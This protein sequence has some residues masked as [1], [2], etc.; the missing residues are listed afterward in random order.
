MAYQRDQ[1]FRRPAPT[2]ACPLPTF[3]AVL[4]E[5]AIPQTFLDDGSDYGTENPDTLL[6]DCWDNGDASFFEEHLIVG[7]LYDGYLSDVE[8]L[9][10]GAYM[11]MWR[12]DWEDFFYNWIVTGT[13]YDATIYTKYHGPDIGG[14]NTNW[15][16]GADGFTEMRHYIPADNFIDPSVEIIIG[17]NSGVDRDVVGGFGGAWAAG[18][19]LVITYLCATGADTP[20]IDGCSS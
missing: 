15:F 10:P 6:W 5:N 19:E 2:G 3:R 7:G 4:S 12:V 14:G 11:V 9:V 1:I 18:T 20:L 8:F 16:Y 13:G 17:Q